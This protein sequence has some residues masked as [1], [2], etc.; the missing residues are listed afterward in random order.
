MLS[1][2]EKAFSPNGDKVKDSLVFTPQIKT[3]S[4]I[5]EYKLTIYDAKENPVKTFADNRALPKSISWNGTSDE[6]ILCSDGTYSAKLFTVSK[7]GSETSVST[8]SFELDTIYP[9]ANV[10]VPYLAFSPNEDKRKDFIPLTISSSAETLWQGQILDKKGNVVKSYSWTGKANS[11][12]WDGCDEAGNI[13]EN[14][15]Y[16]FTISATDQAGNF[17]KAEI[18]DI[19]VDNT[20]VKAYLTAE[21]DSFAPNNDGFRDEQIFSLICLPD[22]GN[23]FIKL[24]QYYAFGFFSL[25]KWPNEGCVL[26]SS[27]QISGIICMF[28][29]AFC[30]KMHRAH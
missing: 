6:G 4:A 27:K 11:F 21:Y 23:I 1:V 30:R 18:K 13:V 19:L 9:E 8:Q 5:V 29:G 20:S 2:S 14:G 12:D 26:S 10:Q 3:S 22:S 17:S 16:S 24:P 7:N 15:K 25:K 28:F